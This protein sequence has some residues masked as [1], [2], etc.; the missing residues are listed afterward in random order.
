MPRVK[1]RGYKEGLSLSQITIDP[2]FNILMYKKISLTKKKKGRAKV[3]ASYCINLHA[4]H[5]HFP[6]CIYFSFPLLVWEQTTSFANTI[7]IVE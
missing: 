3:K 4:Y 5:F 7:L 2:F 1:E 6:F